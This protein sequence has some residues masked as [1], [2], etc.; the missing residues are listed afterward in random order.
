M[1]ETGLKSNLNLH[2]LCI[3]VVPVRLSPVSV[4]MAPCAEIL[5][6]ASQAETVAL[7]QARRLN[8]GNLSHLQLKYGSQAEKICQKACVL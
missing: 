1:R 4:D 6:R 7:S 5:A 3:L 8:V 2:P